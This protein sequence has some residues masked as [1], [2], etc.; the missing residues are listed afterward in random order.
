V[1]LRLLFDE[2]V[3]PRLVLLLSDL[4]PGSLHVSDAG[5]ESKRDSWIWDYAR[6]ECLVVVTKDRDFREFSLDVGAPPKVIWLGL[7]NCTTRLIA[8][9]LRR[10]AIRIAEF[11]ADPETAV[12]ILGTAK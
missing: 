11:A 3:S 2:N 5:L 1:R 7:G 12:L 10:E 6:A 9:I 8:D 4:Y